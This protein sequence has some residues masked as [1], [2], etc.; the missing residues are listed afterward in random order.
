M[1]RGWVV[2]IWQH[3]YHLNL[4]HKQSKAYNIK[5]PTHIYWKNKQNEPFSKLRC[6][7]MVNNFW[8][9][10]DNSTPFTEE[11]HAWNFRSLIIFERDTFIGQ[12][13]EPTSDLFYVSF[14]L[15]TTYYYSSN[16]GVR[17]KNRKKKKPFRISKP[18]CNYL[19]L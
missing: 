13:W 8:L 6:S 5:Q 2:N 9:L 12:F 19:N 11:N 14:K 1:F 3:Q 4:Q 10:Q 16:H 18:H 7:L 17:N 15:W